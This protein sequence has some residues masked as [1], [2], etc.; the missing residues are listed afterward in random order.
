MPLEYYKNTT[1]LKLTQLYNFKSLPIL[2][3]IF[4]IITLL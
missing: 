3:I 4:E 2:L 1:S